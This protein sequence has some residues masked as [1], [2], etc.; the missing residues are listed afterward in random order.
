MSHDLLCKLKKV[1]DVV[2]V[3]L[4]FVLYRQ[5]ALE[6]SDPDATLVEK[7]KQL[8]MSY[9][10]AGVGFVAWLLLLWATNKKSYSSR[11]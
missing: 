7:I 11:V 2:V 4:L 8:P 3:A 6:I 10:F 9:K 1:V 5:K